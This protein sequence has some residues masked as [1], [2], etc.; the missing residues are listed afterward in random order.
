MPQVDAAWRTL[1]QLRSELPQ[2]AR[3]SLKRR[4][5]FNASLEQAEQYFRASPFVGY[6]TRPVLLFYG[7]SQLGRA[8]AAAAARA[9]GD[10][11]WELSGHGIRVPGISQAASS[12]Q[13]APMLVRDQGKGSFTQLAHLLRSPTIPTGVPLA[14]IWNAIPEARDFPLGEPPHYHPLQVG[15]HIDP[16]PSRMGD[17]GAPQA[18]FVSGIPLN[19]TPNVT[20]F[21]QRYPELWPDGK[22]WPADA[23]G[24]AGE[25]VIERLSGHWSGR[26]SP[27]IGTNY[28]GQRLAFPVVPG[29]QWPL[30]AILLWWAT[31]FSLS[32]LA[33]YE[34]AAWTKIID[35]DRSREAVPI[36]H[37]LN[38]AHNSIPGLALEAIAQISMT[39][40]E[41]EKRR[42]ELQQPT[43]ARRPSTLR[44]LRD[45]AGEAVREM[46]AQRRE[47]KDEEVDQG[48]R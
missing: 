11:D 20:D 12:A 27:L 15:E 8:L 45:K 28:L 41:H 44:S 36:E 1:R 7:L 30:H 18:V 24:P 9:P 23:I 40:E 14:D 19:R 42:L 4:N 3:G 17:W 2:T 48:P 37:L 22:G 34:P 26:R 29:S 43:E 38:S 13:I 35:V 47:K 32:M 16:R 5:T 6:E 25:V 10:S 33:R 31:L 46:V 39:D 21:A